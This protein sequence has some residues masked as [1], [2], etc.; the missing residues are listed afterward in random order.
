MV[1]NI[2]HKVTG[3]SSLLHE[4]ILMDYWLTT[5][6]E[7]P[8]LLLYGILTLMFNSHYIPVK[9]ISKQA[10]ISVSHSHPLQVIS[11]QTSVIISR[12]HCPQFYPLLL[13]CYFY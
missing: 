8:F 6:I 9:A 4:M 11:K 3:E 10:A 12:S 5:S 7:K 2:Q 13:S 1:Q